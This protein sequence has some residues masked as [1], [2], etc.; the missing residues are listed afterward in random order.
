MAAATALLRQPDK[1]RLH[2]Q[3][4]PGGDSARTFLRLRSVGHAR[5]QPAELD[6]G[7][8]LAALLECGTDGGGLGFGDDARR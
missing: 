8:E 1:P 7:G 4:L 2:R 6:R 5:E 3:R